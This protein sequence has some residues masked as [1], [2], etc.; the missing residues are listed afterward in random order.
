MIK[1]TQNFIFTQVLGA[2]AAMAAALFGI[3]KVKDQCTLIEQ[4]VCILS[5]ML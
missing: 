4:S 3:S 2:I 1:T 5:H